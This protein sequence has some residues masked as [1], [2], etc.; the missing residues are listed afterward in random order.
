MAQIGQWEGS[1]NLKEEI[2]RWHG[3]SRGL[4]ELWASIF[5]EGAAEGE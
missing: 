2:G 3:G 1:H 5:E 4:G